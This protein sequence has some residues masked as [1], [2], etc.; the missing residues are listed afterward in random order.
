M[1]GFALTSKNVLRICMGSKFQEPPNG[2]VTKKDLRF[3]IQTQD[4]NWQLTASTSYAKA[5][6]LK[7]ILNVKQAQLSF[8]Q[9]LTM[10]LYE[11]PI[12]EK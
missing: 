2:S 4:H 5:G 10:A 1:F 9:A 12:C 6:G 11:S 8:S 7:I 3:E